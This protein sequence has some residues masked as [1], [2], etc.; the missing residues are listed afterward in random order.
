VE[1]ERAISERDR[2]IA[3]A[4]ARRWE[5]RSDR[6]DARIATLVARLSVGDAIPG[7]VA[8]LDTADLSVRT[9]SVPAG[10]PR[11]DPVIV[12]DYGDGEAEG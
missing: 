11:T 1:R 5:E 10:A 2:L 12:V 8:E 9:L 4:D 6:Q 3:Q 7:T